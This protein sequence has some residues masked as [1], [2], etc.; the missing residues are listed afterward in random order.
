MADTTLPRQ[1]GLNMRRH[2]C[3]LCQAC[4]AACGMRA[5]SRY[6]CLCSGYGGSWRAANGKHPGGP[7]SPAGG[8]VFIATA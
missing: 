1:I 3:L 6:R 8:Q 2:W 5:T 4:G 7:A